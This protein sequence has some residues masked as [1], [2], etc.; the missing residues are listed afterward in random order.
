[1]KLFIDQKLT[2]NQGNMPRLHTVLF[3]FTA[4]LA[5]QLGLS[6]FK[7]SYRYVYA[8]DNPSCLATLTLKSESLLKYPG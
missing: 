5:K 6:P 7:C 3:G 2:G 4:N 1:M 8:G